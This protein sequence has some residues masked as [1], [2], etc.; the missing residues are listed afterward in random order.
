MTASPALAAALKDFGAPRRAAAEPFSMPAAFPDPMDFG[1]PAFEAPEI[2]DFP[3]LPPVPE[4]DT[5]ALI[6]EAVARAEAELTERLTRE[7]QDALQL[8]RDRHAEELEVLERRLAEETA[9][10]IQTAIADMEKRVVDLTTAVTARI[11]GTVLTEDVR[12]RSLERLASLI[13]EA[14]HDEE[15][16]RIKVSGS[17]PLFEALKEKLPDYASQFDFTESIGT[18]L[19]VTI[20][21]SMFETRLAEWSA[22]LAEAIE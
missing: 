1:A 9:A 14:L 15:S 12:E 21:D 7:H 17:A 3:E 10:Q 11:L 22:A 13:T 4:V 8:E 6:A 16:V 19:S 20:D 2:P 18:D 5:E